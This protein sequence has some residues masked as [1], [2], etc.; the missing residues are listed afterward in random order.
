MAL[1]NP[2]V[3]ELEL[4]LIDFSGDQK[5][6]DTVESNGTQNAFLSTCEVVLPQM[7]S[8]DESTVVAS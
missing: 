5:P 6:L 8:F 3:P 2:G 7:Q 4:K 1:T